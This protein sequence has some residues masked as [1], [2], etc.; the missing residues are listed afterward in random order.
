MRYLRLFVLLIVFIV[1]FGT[2]G[3]STPVAAQSSSS[4]LR[5]FDL[6]TPQEGWALQGQRLYWTADNG[7]RWVDIT[8][9]TTTKTAIHRA[10]FQDR[11]HGWVV[12]SEPS[13]LMLARTDDTGRIWQSIPLNLF[14]AGD[15]AAL[16]SDFYLHF[17]DKFTGWLVVKQ[18]TSSN[19]SSGTLFGTADGG[20]TWKRLNLPIGEPVYFLN[21]QLGW[22]AG[23]ADGTTFYKTTD[24][25]ATWQLEQIGQA[26]TPRYFQLPFFRD[27]K[28]GALVVIQSTNLETY[29]TSDAGES[30]TLAHTQSLSQAISPRASVPFAYLTVRNSLLLALP[31]STLQEIRQGNTAATALS[32]APANI[33]AMRFVQQGNGLAKT[34]VG[35]CV[36]FVCTITT[37]LW[38]TTDAGQ[39]WEVVH[40]PDTGSESSTIRIQGSVIGSGH[41]FDMCEIA[42][43]GQLQTWRNS[44]PYVSV[45]LYIG[46]VMRTCANSGLSSSFLTQLTQQGWTFI[47]TWVGPQGGGNTCCIAVI[48][49]DTGAAYNQGVNEANAAADTVAN[50]GLGSTV[51]YYD[52]ENYNTNNT[53]YRN[54]VKSFISGWVGQVRARGHKAGV[55][56]AGCGS[57]PVDFTSIPNVPDAV[58][59]AHW[60]YSS[61]NSGASVF[62]V[63]C[64]GDG[65]WSNHERLR[66]YTGGHNENW[67]GVTLNIDSN[68]IDGPVATTSMPPAPANTNLIRNGDFSAG[69]SEWS[70]WENIIAQVTNGVY[71]FHRPAGTQWGAVYQDANYSVPNNAVLEYTLQLGNTSNVE[72]R[73]AISARDI[74]TWNGAIT[75]FFVLPPNTPLRYYSVRGKTDHAWANI[76]T[77]LSM[78]QIDGLAAVALDNITLHYR[79]P[80]TLPSAGSPECSPPP[81]IDQNLLNNPTFASNGAGW[82][83]WGDIN[84]SIQNGVLSVTVPQNSSTGAS[85]EQNRYYML[86]ATTVIEWSAQFGNQSAVNKTVRLSAI[87][88][89]YEGNVNTDILLCNFT[90][91]AGSSLRTYTMRARVPIHWLGVVFHMLPV[92]RD[93]VAG[94]Q[95]AAP[96][97]LVR[98]DLN[99]ITTECLNPPAPTFMPTNTATSTPTNT[100]TATLTPTATATRT[101]TPIPTRADTIGT[102]KDNVF[103]LRHSNTTG[104]AELTVNMAN[105]LGVVAGDLPVVGDWNGDAVDTVGVY[106]SSTGFFFLSSSNI[107]PDATYQVLLGNP[108]DT[109]FAGKWRADMVGDGI[110]VFRPSNGILYQKRELTS[111]FSDYFAVF[112]NP[113]DTGFAGDWDANGLD[114]IGVYRPSNT[115]WYM[116]NNSEPSGITFSDISFVWN[117]G[118]N[119]PVVGDWNG[120]RFTTVGCFTGT[121]FILNNALTAAGEQTVFAYGST[122]QLPVAGKWTSSTAPNPGSVVVNPSSAFSNNADPSAAD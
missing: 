61:Y 87:K 68:V 94:L 11:A 26:G 37:Q 29:V 62:G 33:V 73:V 23:G 34:S 88:A 5:Q 13:G 12:L 76:R 115:T 69:T 36:Q 120:D 52:L 45:N 97:A 38:R 96:S 108:G 7:A 66:Q 78:D 25:G 58:W 35:K 31:N 32:N 93:G 91:P 39:S 51:I 64:L 98:T 119:I 72:K 106:R 59:L 102:F 83:F 77:E 81:P 111:G 67:G 17:T 16:A 116:T 112:G 2:R 103:Y 55:Y 121:I 49:N 101:N 47:P 107:V 4:E 117:I 41:G 19:F 48:S 21:A 9:P 8:P 65:Y 109:P 3:G 104:S 53:T 54:A 18:A 82:T 14:A 22:V 24:G 118:G 56:A 84:Y 92:D 105:V 20:L 44:S 70:I 114:S 75:C 63:A 100:P 27:D 28:H 85:V 10:F 57:M 90:I 40:L 79:P 15:P 89:Y 80:Y 50:L 1:L 95:I 46:G 30:W 110:G 86:P 42:N 113:G 71:Y 43:A 99:V 60:I 74:A 6:V 122:G